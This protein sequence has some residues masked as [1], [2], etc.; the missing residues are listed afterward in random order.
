MIFIGSILFSGAVSA[1]NYT[2]GPGSSYNYHNIT[3]AVEVAKDGDNI[4]VYPNTNG[5][6]YT[7]S[8]AI[9]HKLNITSTG[10]VIVKAPNKQDGFS[11][12]S[13]SSG[14][15]IKGFSI[16]T[17]GVN[18]NNGIYIDS[19]NCQILNNNITKFEYGVDIMSNS[20]T[21]S[22]NIISS[23]PDI[24]GN[25]FGIY[26]HSINNQI[27]NNNI[28]CIGSGTGSP[29]GIYM[30]VYNNSYVSGNTIISTNT[31]TEGAYGIFCS[32]SSKNT[33]SWN[34]I[35]A[36]GPG[37]YVD[38]IHIQSKS[39][40]N[41][42]TGNNLYSS[43][44]LTFTGS[45]IGNTVNFNKII[46]STFY[47]RNYD[48]EYLNALYNWYGSNSGPSS[49]KLIGN[50]NYKPYLVLTLKA[51]PSTIQTI[52][53]SKITADLL[54]DSIGTY[55][56]PT[57]G[58]V[59]NG[60]KVGFL[61]FFNID[62]TIKITSSVSMVNGIA[63]AT[64][65]SKNM[66]GLANVVASLDSQTVKTNVKIIDTIPPKL[67]LTSPTN[68]ATGFSKTANITI[69]FS[70]YI[71]ASSNWSK[72]VIKDKYGH[73]VHITSLISGTTVSIKTNPRAGNSWYTVTI[74]AAAVK[75]YAGNKNLKSCTFKFKTKT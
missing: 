57:T 52:N 15:I 62:T 27:T 61:A 26:V 55:H 42:I 68:G 12:Y 43:T 18:Y 38:A 33:I 39:N 36:T 56:N 50:I 54:H 46:A 32:D 22:N 70:E 71:K 69:K 1:A 11:F 40:Q 53:T 37:D 17:S 35:K 73:A 8:I 44:G 13:G 19:S 49:T 9:Y 31:G 29:Y 51:N 30:V 2:V 21:V 20:N 48:T 41:I 7:E 58:H 66:T 75:D 23:T 64:L 3:S 25:S 63:T 28:N 5:N 14:S 24:D 67:V 6:P 16:T 34:N 4:K 47:I 72:I 60:M 45:S 59:P 74:P 10:K 65:S